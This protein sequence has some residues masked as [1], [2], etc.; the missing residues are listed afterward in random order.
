M[1]RWPSLQHVEY[2]HDRVVRFGSIL[3]F[4]LLVEFGAVLF[5]HSLLGGLLV[6]RQKA[7]IVHLRP[8]SLVEARCRR[9][10][11]GNVSSRRY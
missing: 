6:C 10:R 9:K 3:L 2:R 8:S 4:G 11:P 5:Q 7:D 1:S